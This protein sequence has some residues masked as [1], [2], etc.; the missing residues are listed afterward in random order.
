MAGTG[1]CGVDSEQLWLRE[2]GPRAVRGAGRQSY[3]R[4]EGHAFRERV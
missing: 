2:D 4:A 1:A 3:G